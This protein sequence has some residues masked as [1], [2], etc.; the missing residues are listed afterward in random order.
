M[1][2]LYWK[3][4]L[5]VLVFILTRGNLQVSTVSDTNPGIPVQQAQHG[6]L[7]LTGILEGLVPFPGL[8]SNGNKNGVPRRKRNVLF[9]SGVKVCPHETVHQAVANHLNYFKLGVCQETVW[10]AFKIFWDRLPER[11]EYQRWMKLCE[12]GTVSVFEIGTSFSQSE[13]HLLLVQNRLSLMSQNS[14]C[15]DG[16]CST[17]PTAS[18]AELDNT[19]QRDAAANVSPPQ[20]VSVEAIPSSEDTVNEETESSIT[21]E[22]VDITERPVR[23][24]AEQVVELSIQLTGESYSED[25]ENPDSVRFQGLTKHFIY[26]IQNAFQRLPGFKSVNVIGFSQPQDPESVNAV[27][28]HY[29]VTF[30]VGTGGISNET[31]HFIN[32]HSNK[33]EEPYPEPEESPS[34]V[35]TITDLRNYIAEALSKEAIIGNATLAVDPDSLQLVNEDGSSSLKDSEITGPTEEPPASMGNILAAERPPNG[36]SLEL[37]KKDIFVN[38]Y[39]TGDIYFDS[40]HLNGLWVESET[41]F[42]DENDVIVLEENP[43]SASPLL[44]DP[45]IAEPTSGVDSSVITSQPGTEDSENI[46]EEGFLFS[47][48]V[49]T[50]KTPTSSPEKVTP[51]TVL[52]IEHPTTVAPSPATTQA[53][54]PTVPTSM[55]GTLVTVAPESGLSEGAEITGS[56]THTALPNQKPEAPINT[57]DEIPLPDS[58]HSTTTP[59]SDAVSTESDTDIPATVSP[60]Q[61]PSTSSSVDEALIVT[62]ERPVMVSPSQ[63]PTTPFSSDE[64]LA[65]ETESPVT[66]SALQDPTTPS[67]SDEALAVETES[68]VTVSPL[69]DPTTPSSSDE[70]LA[71]ETESPV[72]VSPLQDP[73]TPSSSD[74]ALAVETES[75][76]IVTPSQDL[77]TPS[78]SDETLVVATESPVMLSLS[79]DP[80][81]PLSFDDA[82]LVTT[83]KTAIASNQLFE[84]GSGSGFFHSGQEPGPDVWPWVPVTPDH[85]SLLSTNEEPKDELIPDYIIDPPDFVDENFNDVTPVTEDSYTDYEPPNSVFIDNRTLSEDLDTQKELLDRVIATEDIRNKPHY[86]T[87]D[88]APV[89]LTMETLTVEL[90]MQTSEASSNYDYYVSE[91]ITMLTPITDNTLP[92]VLEEHTTIA[93]VLEGPSTRG[94][95]FVTVG[96]A[97]SNEELLEV[98]TT[99]ELTTTEKRPAQSVAMGPMVTSH[100]TPGE[101]LTELFTREEE[102]T[103][104]PTLTQPVTETSTLG[105]FMGNI[106]T[107]TFT[108]G[109]AIVGLSTEEQPFLE[110]FNG[111]EDQGGL[112]IPIREQVT[113]SPVTGNPTIE[114]SK[115]DQ[116]ALNLSDSHTLAADLTIK[117]TPVMELFSTVQPTTESPKDESPFTKH[118]AIPPPN[119]ESATMLPV[120]TELPA[121]FHNVPE[122]T[123]L[124]IP[125]EISTADNVFTEIANVPEDI[126]QKPDVAHTPSHPVTETS[127]NKGNS[128]DVYPLTTT[129][130]LLQSTTEPTDDLMV[131]SVSSTKNLTQPQLP[132]I[133]DENEAIGTAVLGIQTYGPAIQDITD[134]DHPDLVYHHTGV[135]QIEEGTSGKTAVN[136]HATDMASVAKSTNGNI[137]L[138]TR[139]LVVFFSLRVTNMIFSED[140]FNKSSP[141]YKALEQ[142]FLEL[143]V[144]YLQ[145]NLTNFQNLE[146]LNFRNGSIV[147]NSR[148]KFAKRVPRNVTN[149][150]YIILE[151]FCNTAYQTM[152]LAIDKYSLDV[153]SGYQADPCKF[154]ACNEFSQCSINRWSGETECVCNAG[155]FSV[156]GLPCQSICELQPD[157]CL[158][159]GKCD[160]IPSKGAICRCRVGENWWYRGEHCEEYV[161]EPLVVGIAIASVAGFL[162][163][164]SAVIFF[165]SR[166]LRDQYS[167]NDIED[168]VR[169]GDS[170]ASMEKAVKYNPMYESDTTTSYSHYYRRY[171]H[172]PSYSSASADASTD[173]S[174]EEIRHIYEHSELTREE[175]QNRIRIIELYAKDQQFAEFVRQHQIRALDVRRGSHSS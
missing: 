150:V 110:P 15:P 48:T 98:V 25:L 160:I 9:P 62:T 20:M 5:Y 130:P 161:S 37:N 148:M 99:T 167:K 165:L 63:Y 145:S 3:S 39:T 33:V 88:V 113:E 35:Y 109:E 29:G 79:Q 90:S 139:A 54:E 126:T 78:S 133:P 158:N 96:D 57:A 129:S 135:S 175:I 32:L 171:P 89:F 116:P 164:A 72:T 19:T 128:N 100:P 103:D 92:N 22:I 151:D 159:D 166:T 169:F 144:P 14:P 1:L 123:A 95:Q 132:V 60:S 71:V 118:S 101:P 87:T 83:E 112:K 84:E 56:Y 81:S 121:T 136:V 138:P 30:E 6:Q 85:I 40:V 23:P 119:V 75:P 155:Y 66:V 17:H 7:Q 174:S 47:N 172:I 170:L 131:I 142:R 21:N 153:E 26:E 55:T 140:L 137:T 53:E 34:V 146:I 106:I 163:V 152:N 143:L 2:D 16:S 64:T 104:S 94:Q 73:T 46:E 80:S 125:D 45:T 74:E 127:I 10:E 117:E 38:G 36:S 147:V 141:E 154:Q 107:E 59:S 108:V 91:P 70:A 162:L 52:N 124:F 122:Q 68:P 69:Q 115:E 82:L 58:T 12:D 13:E 105:I 11:D 27:V 67:S 157:F 102:E 50:L 93:Y 42:A 97:F 173:F 114:I 61:D 111:D 4:F 44:T 149:A 8:K 168:P 156:D 120:L 41:S 134:L 77:T 31:L 65:V 18:T 86:T 43:T 28:V 76:V 24:V 49:V 51:N